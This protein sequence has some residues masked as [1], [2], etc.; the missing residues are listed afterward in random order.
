MRLGAAAAP[1]RGD[2]VVIGGYMIRVVEERP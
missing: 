1:D 2:V